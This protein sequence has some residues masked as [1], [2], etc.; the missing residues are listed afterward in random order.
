MN[1]TEYKTILEAVQQFFDTHCKTPQDAMEVYNIFLHLIKE[2]IEG[3]NND[4]K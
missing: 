2:D 3:E 1:K 4:N